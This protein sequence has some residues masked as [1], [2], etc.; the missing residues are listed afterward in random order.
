MAGED[1]ADPVAWRSTDGETWTTAPM[2]SLPG[3]AGA[4]GLERVIASERGYLAVGYREEET[5]TF[6][7]S[8]DGL[9]WTQTEDT[10]GLSPA[11]VFALAA[12]DARVVVG[13]QL[14]GGH[15]FIWSAPL[16]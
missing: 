1:R 12:S 2:D 15:A 10:P 11:S 4:T 8:H 9:S 14:P 7:I 3:P 13:G 5:P 6:W 16:E